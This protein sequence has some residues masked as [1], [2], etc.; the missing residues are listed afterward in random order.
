[1]VWATQMSD[2]LETKLVEAKLPE[3]ACQRLR[4]AFPTDTGGMQEAINV[5][6]RLAGFAPTRPTNPMRQVTINLLAC[7]EAFK[8]IIWVR[9]SEYFHDGVLLENKLRN[10]L[11]CNMTVVFPIENI[12]KETR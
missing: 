11:S 10:R 3:A 12:S 6:R 1:M 8:A 5:E 2:Y 9:E 4:L 7:G